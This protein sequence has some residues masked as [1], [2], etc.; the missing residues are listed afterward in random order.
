[1]IESELAASLEH[2][3]IV[4]IYDAGEAE[5]LLYIAMRFVAGTDLKSLIE[6]RE[7]SSRDAPGVSSPRFRRPWTPP[8]PRA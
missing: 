1:M 5:G 2:P 6:R 7:P 4:P 3:N 8:T